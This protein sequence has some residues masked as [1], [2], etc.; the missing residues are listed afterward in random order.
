[1]AFDTIKI[2]TDAWELQKIYRTGEPRGLFLAAYESS[3]IIVAIK[4]D[5]NGPITEYFPDRQTATRWL[6][7]DGSKPNIPKSPLTELAQNL[8][9][10]GIW[11]IDIEPR[12]DNLYNV[13]FQTYDGMFDDVKVLSLADAIEFLKVLHDAQPNRHDGVIDADAVMQVVLPMVMD[14]R[15]V[16][17]A[18]GLTGRVIDGAERNKMLSECSL[19]TNLPIGTNIDMAKLFTHDAFEIADVITDRPNQLILRF[20]YEGVQYHVELHLIVPWQRTAAKDKLALNIRVDAAVEDSP[21]SQDILV[22]SAKTKRVNPKRVIETLQSYSAN[23]FYDKQ[24]MQT[25]AVLSAYARTAVDKAIFAADPLIKPS[26]QGH[27][28]Y[29]YYDQDSD[30]VILSYRYPKDKRDNLDKFQLL[31]DAL[32]ELG[33]EKNY[34]SFKR[35]L[36]NKRG[37]IS[38]TTPGVFEQFS[39]YGADIKKY[40][41][42]FKGYI[43]TAELSVTTT[44]ASVRLKFSAPRGK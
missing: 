39:W 44:Q 6:L 30:T 20:T 8:N 40:D 37:A 19:M 42:W 13:H 1:M 25:L 43:V 33:F 11:Q 21:E 41:D 31:K 10:D 35:P 26:D 16:R 3:D 29:K 18:L 9:D 15:K 12:V 28:L 7:E 27:R 36:D 22:E 38:M 4:N 17:E 24:T 23:E 5:H 14:D 2:I 32:L 34:D